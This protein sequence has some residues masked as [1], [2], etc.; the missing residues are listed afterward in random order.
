MKPQGLVAAPRQQVGGVGVQSVIFAAVEKMSEHAPGAQRCRI[1][2]PA[3]LGEARGGLGQ[4][5]MAQVVQCPQFEK[6]LALE[7]GRGRCFQLPPRFVK[8]SGQQQVLDARHGGPGL[9]GTETQEDDRRQDQEQQQPQP[10]PAPAQLAVL[11]R[12][13]NVLVV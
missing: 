4:P 9:Q 10:A 6:I 2:L 8:A 11:E 13:R 12:K 3:Q 7:K 1:A 5:A